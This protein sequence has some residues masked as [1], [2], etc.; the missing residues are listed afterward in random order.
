MAEEDGEDRTEA[1]TPR[2]L[3]KAR[4][5]G[6]VAVSREA[7]VLAV[8]AVPAVMLSVQGPQMAA[9]LSHQLAALLAMSVTDDPLVALRFAGLATVRAVLPFLGAA[10][11]AAAAAVLLQ[12]G[13]ILNTAA[14]MPNP[15]RLSPAHGLAR[16]A[17]MN[18][19]VELGKSLLKLGAAGAVIWSVLGG[20]ARLLPGALHWDPLTLLDRTTR[21]VLRVAIALLGAQA[22]ITAFDVVRT[23][24]AHAAGLRMT[25][26]QVREELK[27]SEGDPH[28]KSRQKRVRMQR[29]RRRMLQAVPKATVVITNPTHYA[30]ALAYDRN[31]QAAPR[32]VAK[33]VDAMAAR[34]REIARDNR[35]PLVANPPLARALY[36]V[37]LDAEIP[38]ELFQ[39]VADIIAT[40]WGLRRRTA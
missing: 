17:S 32:V 14:L 1:A 37:E 2:Q 13:G 3:Q 21:E 10:I 4:Q 19:L 39:A 34:I 28:V 30:V 7:P 8:L 36:P 29:A 24:A 23:R 22:A 18:A 20:S 26:E 27:E 38:R 33:G 16:I 12:T 5:S 6:S 9:A 31:A 40:I 25:R 35:V 11:L 15:A